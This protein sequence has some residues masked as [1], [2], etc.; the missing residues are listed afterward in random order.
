MTCACIQ[1]LQTADEYI[2]IYY[3]HGY[4]M[5]YKMEPNYQNVL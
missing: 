3:H 2:N 5:E 1:V 4:T